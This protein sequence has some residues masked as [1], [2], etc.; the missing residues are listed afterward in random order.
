MSRANIPEKE[1]KDFCLYVDEFQ[2]FST[3]SFATIMS[4]A[5]KYHLNL[6]VA[7]Q[8][9]TQL[10]EEI[11][12]AVFGNMGTIV[13]FRIG[14]N[15]V[16]SLS[17]YFQPLFDG[18][19]L[20]RVPNF[21]TVVRTLV[22]GVP[23]QPFSM[24]TMP[25]LGEPN[26]QLA[27]AL[28]QLSAAKYGKPKNQVETEIFARLGT[29]EEPKPAFSA[30][31]FGAAPAGQPAAPAMKPPTPPAPASFLD[32]W[33]AK[34]KQVGSGP[35]PSAAPAAP[36]PRPS[37]FEPA[38]APVAATTATPSI[39]A[40]PPAASMPSPTP[41]PPQSPAPSLPSQ[42]SA[43]GDVQ[44]VATPKAE[45]TEIA[46]IADQ[47]RQQMDSAP[48][49]PVAPPV[50]PMAEPQPEPK[51]QSGELHIRKAHEPDATTEDTIV[52]DR[53]GTFHVRDGVA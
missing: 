27:Q 35:G 28:K 8:F 34:R 48:V 42:S 19:D 23:T 13:S 43:P 47:L 25:P 45:H 10:S 12:D 51:K 53:D 22:G 32:D 18:D 11:R 7:N 14:Q 5:R 6:I 52:I 50:I 20:L 33:L 4:E 1:R 24:A 3:D 44:T 46:Q 38:A 31:P 15:D 39:P 17:R 16:E 2:N 26:P 36:A 29:K 9:T 21:N 49:A 30:N 37:P 40:M 41:L